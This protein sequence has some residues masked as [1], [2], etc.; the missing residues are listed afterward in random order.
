MA[1]TKKENVKKRNW[2]FVLYPESAPADWLERLKL[3]G[4][5]SAISPL[6]DKDINPTGEPKKAHYH[7]LL[8]Y[9]GPT[10]YNAVAKFTASLNATIPQALESV[11][12]MYRYFSH[13]DNPEKYQ[14]DESDI[15][16]VNGFNISDLI[17]LTKSEVNEIKAN[18]LKL[19]REI[20]IVEYSD[21]IDFLTDNEMMAEYDVAIN[22]TFFFNTY[23]TS[24]RNSTSFTTIKD[25][26]KRKSN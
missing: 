3:S 4:L 25:E 24:K 18:I 26:I 14:Y 9:S 19:I 13:K 5:M 22:N 16:N 2:T 6:H 7:V 10:T 21:L 1:E 11:R 17:E 20:G 12:G 15:L 23:I 8:V